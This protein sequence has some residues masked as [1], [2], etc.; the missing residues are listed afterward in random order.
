[1]KDRDIDPKDSGV[2]N[3]YRALLYQLTG[4]GV[5]RPR[6]QNGADIWRKSHKDH[7]E[8]QARDELK[9]ALG[10]EL[11][12]QDHKQLASVRERVKVKMYKGLSEDD[13]AGWAEQAAELNEAA[14]AKWE[15]DRKAPP[16]SDPA[17]H[18]RYVGPDF[19]Y[20]SFS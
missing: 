15:Q 1:M 18:Q 12:P 20:Y 9:T 17:D 16:S 11:I 7:I 13:R 10:R 6:A 14:R 5:K 19:S 8:Q 4:V 2:D 3:P